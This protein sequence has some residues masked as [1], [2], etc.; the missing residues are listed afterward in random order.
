[1]TERKLNNRM[2]KIAELEAQQKDLMAQIEALKAEVKV[3]MDEEGKELEETGE[4]VIRY[5][6]IQTDRFDTKRF[7]EEHKTLYA[8]YLL[9][10]TQRRFTFKGVA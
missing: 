10:V 1:M 4:F 2:R 9:P 8:K 5:A 6:T 7:K 3:H